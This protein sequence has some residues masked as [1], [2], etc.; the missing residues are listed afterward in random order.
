MKFTARVAGGVIAA[1]GLVG[2][3]G[4]GVTAAPQGTGTAESAVTSPPAPS[5]DPV[6]I[7][8]LEDT[9]GGT[10]FTSAQ[11]TLGIQLAIDQLNAAG[12]MAGRPVKLIRSS[13]G[14]EPSQ[15]PAVFRKLVEEGATFILT[16]S[17]SASAAQ[18]KPVAV[19]TSTPAMSPTNIASNIATE[20]DNT[21]SF[22]LANP[23]TDVGVTYSEAFKAAGI[24]KVAVF[25]DDSP[26]IAGLSKLLLPMLEESGIEIVASETAPLDALDFT[27]QAARISSAKPDAILVISLGGQPEVLFHNIAALEMPDIPRFSLASIGNQPETWKLADPAALEGVVY[28]ASIDPANTR[29]TGLADELAIKPAELTAFTAQGYDSV[30][31]IKAAVEAA[32]GEPKGAALRDGM[33]S[34]SGYR[35]HFGQDAFTISFTADKHA[36]TDGLCG[37]LLRTFG[38]D[39]LPGE[40][41]ATY[42]PACGA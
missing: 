20:P 33:F 23:I 8:M 5:G 30:Y 21:F 6:V 2:L 22:I 36:G 13:D 16:N 19:E 27:A 3:P 10:A 40:R 7:G 12:G 42:Q 38:G 37:I 4:A 11:A 24:K 28:I 41:W 1:I 29:S 31:L 15:A 9:S 32:Q 34:I 35:P 18:V 39:N 25:A 14:G 26:T 17:G